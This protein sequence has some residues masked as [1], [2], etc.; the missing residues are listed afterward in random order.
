M[1]LGERRRCELRLFNAVG[2]ATREA[3]ENGGHLPPVCFKDALPGGKRTWKSM[4]GRW[5]TTV[6]MAVGG[7]ESGRAGRRI[8]GAQRQRAQGDENRWWQ[9]GSLGPV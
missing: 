9:P 2:S 6:S 7:C 3:A 5:A 1:K 4:Q 8:V